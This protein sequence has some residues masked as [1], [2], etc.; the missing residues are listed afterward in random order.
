MLQLLLESAP[1]PTHL[2]NIGDASTFHPKR[3]KRDKRGGPLSN[4]WGRGGG[5]G[6]ANFDSKK[7]GSLQILVP[8]CQLL[9]G[10]IFLFLAPP[11]L[12][13]LNFLSALC[14]ILFGRS[15]GRQ[16]TLSSCP[17]ILSPNYTNE[18]SPRQGPR[19]TVCIWAIWA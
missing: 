19:L 4:R 16:A 10:Y 3:R 9:L 15:F 18:T 1:S 8:C 7:L 11:M 14:F 5:E 13:Y 17:S 6:G 2:A 12:G